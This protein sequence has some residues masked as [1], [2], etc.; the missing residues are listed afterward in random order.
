MRKNKT[1][2]FLCFN[3]GLGFRKIKELSPRALILTSGTLSPMNSF[4]QE[5]MMDFPIKS[6][7]DHV[8][9]KAQAKIS[10]IGKGIQGCEFNFSHKFRDDPK[11]IMDLG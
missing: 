3:P 7:C 1:L 10:I 8:I 9:D 5:L 11:M 4:Q 2:S 6:E